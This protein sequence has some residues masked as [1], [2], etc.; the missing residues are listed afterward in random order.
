MNISCG[1]L[2]LY[3]SKILLGH[4]TNHWWW[5][6]P[7]GML[8]P[9]ETEVTGALRELKEETGIQANPQDLEDLGEFKYERG[10]NLHLF[11]YLIPVI[12][13]RIV[14]H[15]MVPVHPPFPELDKFRWFGFEDINE[16]VCLPQMLSVLEI[17]LPRN[18]E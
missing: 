4:V 5:D 14:C 6:L 10:K 11:K 2:V 17:L 9:G 15:S 3:H 8:E 12:P 13:S 1:V 7:K 18:Q 16:E